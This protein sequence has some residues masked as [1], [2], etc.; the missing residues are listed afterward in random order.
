M[1]P[2]QA[3]MLAG[4]A[5]LWGSSYPLIKYALESFSPA[6]I[7]FLRGLLG[8]ATLALVVKA[9]KAEAWAWARRIARRPGRAAVFGAVAIA[10]PF[11]LISFGE[12]EVPAGL[13][14]ILLAPAPIFAAL[15]TGVL[16]P[17]T[18]IA[19]VQVAGIVAGFVGVALVVGVE[20]ISTLGQFLGG[21]AMVAAALCYA[22]S[23]FA[24]RRWYAGAP[25]EATSLVAAAVTAL[26]LLVPG[27]ATAHGGAPTARAVVAIA[28]LGIGGTALAF[29]IMFRLY[30][31]VGPAKATLVGYLIPPVSLAWG[32]IALDEPLTVAAVAGLVLILAGV[33]LAASHRPREAEPAE[34]LAVDPRA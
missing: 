25:S 6:E 24:V 30:H 17:G 8:A 7:V 26:L 22:L 14:A 1:T 11:S 4:L 12:L 5:L 23:G 2:R 28:V 13:T 21:I 10:L 27:L 20:S 33:A 29:V 18:R 34:A 31:E 3:G 19:P 16:E 9:T 32:V 15:L